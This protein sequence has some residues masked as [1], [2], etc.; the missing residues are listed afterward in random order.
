MQTPQFA[1]PAGFRPSV[2]G[3]SAANPA[4]L[5]PAR[6]PTTVFHS[7]TQAPP[8]LSFRKGSKASHSASASTES[9]TWAT[10]DGGAT[11][12]ARSL[13]LV[14]RSEFWR[15]FRCIAPRRVS[16]GADIGAACSQICK[17]WAFILDTPRQ[18]WRLER[19]MVGLHPTFWQLLTK[20]RQRK[21]GWVLRWI[22]RRWRKILARRRR[23]QQERAAS[24]K[25]SHAA[26]SVAVCACP[27]GQ[28]RNA[29]VAGSRY[30][31]AHACKCGHLKRSQQPLCEA[32]A[33][34]ANARGTPATPP[35]L[36]ATPV[37]PPIPAA[38]TP[39]TPHT[40]HTPHTP[41]T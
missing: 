1:A 17:F 24:G 15:N 41:P 31:T 12:D 22:Q 18:H 26:G 14:E 37:P 34:R 16:G 39:S 23:H 29:P 21:L 8:T 33:G 32:C 28:C 27:T 25:R 5:P 2:V 20:Q 40:P 4:V 7:I 3:F 36:Q 13:I 19:D 11:M 30:C 35:A 9:Q 10:I 38:A 6:T